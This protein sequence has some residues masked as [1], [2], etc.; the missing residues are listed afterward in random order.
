MRL[1]IDPVK[2]ASWLYQAEVR[3]APNQQNVE[4]P[5]KLTG[6]NTELTV[7]TVGNLYR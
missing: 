5:G 6:N 4:L 3:A 1:W 2:L 7:K